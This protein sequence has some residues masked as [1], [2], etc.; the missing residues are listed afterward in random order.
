M[1]Q[2]VVNRKCRK[3]KCSQSSATQNRVRPLCFWIFY[4]AAMSSRRDGIRNHNNVSWQ[5]PLLGRCKNTNKTFRKRQKNGHIVQNV[6][7]RS[8]FY[9]NKYSDR[10]MSFFRLCKGIARS[11]SVILSACLSEP[12]LFKCP[13]FL[14]KVELKCQIKRS[15]Q[16]KNHFWNEKMPTAALSLKTT[17]AQPILQILVQYSIKVGLLCDNLNANYIILLKWRLSFSLAQ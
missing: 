8:M 15:A 17:K 6:F 7:I 5:N 9:L 3:Y 14:L 11:L 16:K 10:A 4:A 12:I 1:K 13:G 2:R